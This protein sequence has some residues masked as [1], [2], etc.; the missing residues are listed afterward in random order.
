MQDMTCA[1]LVS[2][3]KRS[4]VGPSSWYSN[5]GKQE[6]RLVAT[7]HLDKIPSVNLCD[8]LPLPGGEYLIVVHHSC[9]KVYAVATQAMVWETLYDPGS[10]RCQVQILPGQVLSWFNA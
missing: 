8:V 1:E 9:L 2:L 7:Q 5:D 10:D 3:V 4:V 6:A